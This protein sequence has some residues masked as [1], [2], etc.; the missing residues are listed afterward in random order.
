M[1]PEISEVHVD[2]HHSV[3]LRTYDRGVAIQLG[4]LR[5]LEER[6]TTFDAAWTELSDAERARVTAL[7][8][9]AR[10]DQVTVAFAKD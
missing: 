5:E 10:S 1:R 4:A 8:L 3:T 9:D 6:L 7:H 2:A